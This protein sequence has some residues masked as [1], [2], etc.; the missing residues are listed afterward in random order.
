MAAAQSKGSDS[1]IPKPVLPVEFK[2]SQPLYPWTSHRLS[3][4]ETVLDET[5]DYVYIQ[6]DQSELALEA[7]HLVLTLIIVRKLGSQSPRAYIHL[8][9]GKMS[10]AHS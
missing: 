8:N 6:W 1:E 7:F 9:R 10:S 5:Q 3:S 4:W 2:N